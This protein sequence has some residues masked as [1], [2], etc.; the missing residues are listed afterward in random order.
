MLSASDLPFRGGNS[1]LFT[2]G[3]RTKSAEG[4]VPEGFLPPVSFSLQTRIVQF[5]E[6]GMW[7]GRSP[8]TISLREPVSTLLYPRSTVSGDEVS[9]G[10]TE[11]NGS[12]DDGG[13]GTYD[14]CNVDGRRTVTTATTTTILHI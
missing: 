7:V 14:G 6:E 1:G 9:V 13:R 8:S 5:F 3:T 2:R 12:V 11:V 4:P 10:D